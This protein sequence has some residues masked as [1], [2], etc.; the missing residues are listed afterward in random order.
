[1]ARS[2]ITLKLMTYAPTG[3]VVAAPTAG[4]P[5]QAGGERNWD[6]RYTWIRNGS[7]S[8][9]A[10]L[11]LGFHGGGSRLRRLAAGLRRPVGGRR[12]P[13]LKIMYRVDGS[14]DLAEE[15][16]DHFE[17]WRGSRPV[18]IG[19]GAADQLQLDIYG[20]AMDAM[21]LADTQGLQVAHQGW[22]DIARMI[23]WVCDNW[24]QPD[25]GI[26]ETRGGRKDFTYGRFQIWVALDRATRM[27]ER[28]GRPANVQRWTTERDRVYNQIIE[29][30]GNPTTRAFT[31]HY[32][33]EVLDSSLR[34]R[35]AP[36]GCSARDGKVA[37]YARCR[38][39]AKVL[40]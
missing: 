12:R 28:R 10:L 11:G 36:W 1:V 4:L 2:A 35:R 15:T 25:E 32:T 19:N 21:Y 34:P 24:D 7:F 14:S 23:D 26:W 20:E 29:R 33:T 8:I 30:G 37:V 9:Y 6:Y 16:L 40:L 27:A 38:M 22:R 18:R 31:Q 39:A 5:E 17:G 3:A 13:P